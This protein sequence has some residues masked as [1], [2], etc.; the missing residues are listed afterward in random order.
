MGNAKD[1]AVG[2]SCARDLYEASVVDRC[3]LGEMD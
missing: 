3:L 2:T 1:V